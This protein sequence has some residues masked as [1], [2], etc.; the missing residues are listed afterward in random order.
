MAL[1]EEDLKFKLTIDPDTAKLQASIKEIGKAIDEQAAKAKQAWADLGASGT[2]QMEA[3][4]DRQKTAAGFEKLGQAGTNQ[5]DQVRG[6][7]PALPGKASDVPVDVQSAEVAKKG[8]AEGLSE[9]IVGVGALG[10][11][12]EGLGVALAAITAGIVGAIA[13]FNKMTDSIASFVAV[14]SPGVFHQWQ[15]VL[16]DIAGVIGQTLTPALV[17][18]RDAFRF[19]GDILATLLPT[20]QELTEMLT[21]LRDIFDEFAQSVRELLDEMGPELKFAINIVFGMIIAGFMVLFKIASDFM[22][23]VTAIH[24][25]LGIKYEPTEIKSSVGAAARPAHFSS[26][27]EFEKGF[28]QAALSSSASIPEQ[29]LDK[30]GSIESILEQIRDQNTDTGPGFA[31]RATATA[32]TTGLDLTD[33]PFGIRRALLGF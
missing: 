7:A 1:N 26:L 23:L 17:L 20:A 10:G 2:A 6:I 32:V 25:L 4:R 11:V 28:Q 5:L 31:E 24:S 3:I 29:Q 30:L 14:A 12:L 8:L 22:R 16:Q 13:I 27:E 18:L 33:D 15:I 19:F 9:A 21:P